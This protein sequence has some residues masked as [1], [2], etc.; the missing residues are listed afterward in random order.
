M[1]SHQDIIIGAGMAGMK[2]AIGLAGGV[3][4]VVVL[5][6]RDCVVGRLVSVPSTTNRGVCYDFVALWF[7]EALVN[8][9]LAKARRLGNVDIF[10]DHGKHVTH[11]CERYL[12]DRLGL[13]TDDQ[14]KYAPQVLRMWD[15]I[16]TGALWDVLS[17]RDHKERN[18]FVYSGYGSLP[19]WFQ[20]HNIRT[21]FTVSALDYMEPASVRVSKMGGDSYTAKYGAVTVP[22]N[23]LCSRKPTLEWTPPLS[24]R[25]AEIFAQDHRGLLVKVVFDGSPR[26]WKHPTLAVNYYAMA[27]VPS[28]VFLTQDPLS[29]HLERMCD[30]DIWLLFE[31]VVRTF[32]TGLV[33]APLKILVTKWN[34]D[35]LTQDLYAV[36]KVGGLSTAAVCSAFSEGVSKRA[37]F[38]GAQTQPGSANWCAHCAWYSGQREAA[39]VLG[40]LAREKGV[41]F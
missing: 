31:P 16:W 25:L 12:E 37:R 36:P 23:V 40:Q 24:A 41:R 18:A 33:D 39:F 8:Q 22:L 15:E 4:D 1:P 35:P 10:F 20:E 19:A 34:L 21:N 5:E 11:L 29:A 27:R 9:L 2:T 13:L 26:A 30:A 28:L 17:A 32:A 38:A 3:D 7:H 6:A 14:V